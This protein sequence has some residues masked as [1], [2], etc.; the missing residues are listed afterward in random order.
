MYMF[1]FERGI[2]KEETIKQTRIAWIKKHLRDV[3]LAD[4]FDM[5]VLGF[6]CSMAW[7]YIM[8][9]STIIHFST[10]N[11][12][13]HFNSVF[14][15]S[16]LGI[17]AVLLFGAILL[18]TFTRIMKRTFSKTVLIAIMSVSA[19]MLVLVDLDYFRQPWCSLISTIAGLG[20]GVM[21]LA[22]GVVYKELSPT[23]VIVKASCAF[24]VASLIF[25]IVVALP[26]EAGVVIAVLLPIAI[27]FI[28][29]KSIGVWSK[30]EQPKSI[31]SI[32]M[33]RTAF[34]VRSLV[35]IGIISFA[36]S[37]MQAL[38]FN[39]SP[40]I[41][42]GSYP[43]ALL[44]ATI[45]SAS[46]ICFTMLSSENLD[47]GYAY[48]T[49]TFVLAFIFLL[50]P[51]L[52]LGSF[53]ASIAALIMYSLVSLLVWIV[54][55]KI[56]GLYGLSALFVFGIGWGINIAGS[57]AGTFGG[58]LLGSFLELTPRILSLI[59]LICICLLFLAFSFI[60]DE[61]SIIK[62]TGGEVNDN[63]HHRPFHARCEDIARKN[64]LTKRETEVMVLL[65]KGRSNPHIQEELDIASGTINTHMSH[66]YKKLDIH[67]RQ[68][69][70]DLIDV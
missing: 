32:S 44:I 38:F 21:Y 51:I 29:F 31:G 30:T 45:I 37:L 11:D 26:R 4:L 1:F 23:R 60:F 40:I 50:L 64:G 7:Y 3:T 33:R 61:K 14:G 47:Y 43:W 16:S 41:N 10:R 9:F 62:L 28:L 42:E 12:V 19:I 5:K 49:I 53:Q 56:A 22:W 27:G 15:F 59:T 66:I 34:F 57:L 46:V 63:P 70:L 36:E 65:A 58:A 17:L 52:T 69:L 35:S 25:A 67:D 24:L 20:I 8:F 48:K 55:T 6:A 68:E 54:L 2:V 18:K 13:S 39:A